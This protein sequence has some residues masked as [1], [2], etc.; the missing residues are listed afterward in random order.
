MSAHAPPRFAASVVSRLAGY[1]WGSILVISKLLIVPVWFVEVDAER[2]GGGEVADFEL[3][4]S[5][6]S[7]PVR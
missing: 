6:R 5:A 2:D 3:R 1:Y 4:R 7:S